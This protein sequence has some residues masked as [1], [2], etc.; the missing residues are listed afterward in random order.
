MSYPK[1][2]EERLINLFGYTPADLQNLYKECKK[3]KV[4]Y[5]DMINRIDN[6]NSIKVF[7]DMMDE[8]NMVH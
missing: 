4:K 2:V 6:H 3:D 8:N 5:N 7:N 1:T